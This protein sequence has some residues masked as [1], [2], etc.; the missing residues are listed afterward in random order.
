M[1]THLLIDGENFKGMIKT[2]FKQVGKDRPVWHQY[3][4]KGLFAEVLADDWAS[5]EA[6]FYFARIKLHEETMDKSRQLIEEHRLLKAHL[7]QQG[8]KV[9]LGGLVRG[10][11]ESAPGGRHGLVFKEKGVD[12]KIAVDM[13]SLACDHRA[14]EIILASSDSD[15]QPAIAEIQKRGV[16]C[17]YLGFRTT[18][19][20]GMSYTA[21]R[22]VL[23]SNSD[24][25]AFGPSM[26]TTDPRP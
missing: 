6:V 22:T 14:S 11:M 24:V 17:V 21:G 4:F 15:L 13:V 1:T 26:D 18:P 20:K 7:E 2:V 5:I 23:I 12:V 19:N 9:V 16:T 8:F 3:D 10:Q 25:L